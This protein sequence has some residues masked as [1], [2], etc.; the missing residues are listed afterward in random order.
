MAFRLKLP[1]G[2]FKIKVYR[3]LREAERAH[4]VPVLRMGRLYFVWWPD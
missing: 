4:K 1:G 2:T 3:E